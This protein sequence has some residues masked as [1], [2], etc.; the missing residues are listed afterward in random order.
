ME[1]NRCMP[2]INKFVLSESMLSFC[3]SCKQRQITYKEET[4]E[5]GVELDYIYISC[6]ACIDVCSPCICLVPEKAR[7]GLPFF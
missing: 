4:E 2:V 7:K 1:P 5:L 6:F 3:E